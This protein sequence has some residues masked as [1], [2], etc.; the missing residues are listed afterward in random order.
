VP[1]I[2]TGGAFHGIPGIAQAPGADDDHAGNGLTTMPK[3][4]KTS[5]KEPALRAAAVS[6]LAV[7][8]ALTAAATIAV[9][10][11]VISGR[12][13]GEAAVHRWELGAGFFVESAVGAWMVVLSWRTAWCSRLSGAGLLAGAL[14]SGLTCT[15]YLAAVGT[16]RAGDVFSSLFGL[17]W[18]GSV[19]V[20]GDALALALAVRRPGVAD[21][22]SIRA[23]LAAAL[24]VPPLTAGTLLTVITRRLCRAAAWL[25]RPLVRGWL[26]RSAHAARPVL[27]QAPRRL[28][29]LASATLPGQDVPIPGTAGG[30]APAAASSPVVLAAYVGRV[31]AGL[32]VIVATAVGL[33][34]A[35]FTAPAPPFRLLATLTGA[36]GQHVDAVAFSPNGRILATG[37]DDHRARLWTTATGQLIA[38]LTV[39]TNQPLPG[40]KKDGL[41]SNSVNTVVFSPDGRMLATGSEDGAVRLWTLPAGRL[42]ATFR[43]RHVIDGVAFGPGGRTLAADTDDGTVWLWSIATGQAATV[44]TGTGPVAYGPGG[45]TLAAAEPTGFTGFGSIRLQDLATGRLETTL[46]PRGLPP[47]NRMVGATTLA[48]SPGGRSLAA[49]FYGA[50]SWWD[51]ATRRA[52]TLDTTVVPVGATMYP[53]YLVDSVAFSPRAQVLAAGSGDGIARLWDT[54]TGQLT[55][56]ITTGS[57]TCN[58]AF[59]PDGRTLATGTADGAT[60]LWDTSRL[61]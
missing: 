57:D 24:L 8:L 16:L 3:P 38:T 61:P 37:Q 32:A 58:V 52:I 46:T 36:S 18:V 50:V 11:A 10:V 42:A 40:E 30:T 35:R 15:L 39:G 25:A 43:V 20:G 26:R 34:I 12:Q 47:L 60:R 21:R 48:F 45:H 7:T 28:A 1:V 5:G 23:S 17:V 4:G 44:A 13:S 54:A 27:A 33:G 56:T 59:S 41:T 14:G 53:G 6:R 19:A 2:C 29:A 31:T 22:A 55:A 49:G 51:V 9:T